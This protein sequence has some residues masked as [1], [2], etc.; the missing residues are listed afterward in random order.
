MEGRMTYGFLFPYSIAYKVLLV[1][2]FF[3]YQ[4]EKNAL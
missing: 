1:I 2:C 4:I 3:F